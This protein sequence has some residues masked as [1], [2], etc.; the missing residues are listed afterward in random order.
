MG[1]G[2]S[3]YISRTITALAIAGSLAT[4][5]PSFAAGT[6][7]AVSGDSKPSDCGSAKKASYSL[8][9]SGSLAGC[10]SV[11]V[12]HFNCQEMNGFA[13]YTEIGREEFAGKADGKNM[14]FDTQYTFNGIFPT[15]SCPEP[16]A[17]KEIVGGCVHYITGK[18]LVGVMRFYDVMYSNGAP[19]Y[20]YEGTL[21]PT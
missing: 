11:F 13:L 20:F 12:A 6:T 19:H 9:L 15:G 5:G 1:R 8:E 14:T 21:S 18:G 2:K 10:W 3:A 17:E 7:A 4:A 16:A